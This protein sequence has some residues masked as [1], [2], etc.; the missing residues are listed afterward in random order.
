M[1]YAC[2]TPTH[3]LNYPSLFEEDEELVALR[4]P[5]DPSARAD[6]FEELFDEGYV[7]LGE[8]GGG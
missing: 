7:G 2:V 5:T 1:L 8:G 6:D 3:S 4:T